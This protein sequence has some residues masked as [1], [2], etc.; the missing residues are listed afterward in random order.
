MGLGRRAAATA[1][2]V[3]MT[4]LGLGAAGC[5][6]GDDG[7]GGGGTA[8]GQDAGTPP[9]ASTAPVPDLVD[10]ADVVA[11]LDGARLDEV[12]VL[13][14]PD[15]RSAYPTSEVRAVFTDELAVFSDT[16]GNLWAVDRDTG[17]PRWHV[18]M[19]SSLPGGDTVCRLA[20][21]SPDA[22]V[23]VANHGGGDLCGE[24]TVYDLRTGDVTLSYS[25]LTREARASGFRLSSNLGMFQLG[26]ST[27]WVDQE[28]R[29][30]RLD[31]TGDSSTV[32]S[33]VILDDKYD[34]WNLA[35][36]QV[37][38][39]T[40]V[41]VARMI[42]PQKGGFDPK[43]FGKP[44]DR[45]DVIGFRFGDD[46]QL[47][48]VFQTS[49]A[50]LVGGAGHVRDS[51]G[52][53]DVLPGLVVDVARQHGTR[54]Y[55]VRAIDPE[56]GELEQPGVLAPYDG[57]ERGGDGVP[58]IAQEYGPDLSLVVGDGTVL[59][60]YEVP[61]RV[62]YTSVV[63]YDM[64]TGKRLW[65]WQLPGG[66][67]SASPPSIKVL[68]VTPD[69]TSAYVFTAMDF[70]NEIRELDLETGRSLRTWQL[71]ERSSYAYEFD[72]APTFVDGDRVLQVNGNGYAR[73]TSLAAL[74]STG[75]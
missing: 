35:R 33:P 74:F 43:T 36:F 45:G 37:I 46:D 72:F 42:P 8:T 60:P 64:A 71:P 9:S 10:G 18:R 13:P 61:A 51:F 12:R 1:A 17:R 75:G 70:D 4:V 28:D 54:Y 52:Q 19:E 65:T 6:S 44:T 50:R 47:E 24:F 62:G 58:G 55:R 29:V 56:S 3:V 21:P 23:V 63:R 38:P 39:G 26:E 48:L 15:Y 11:P 20:L 25:S 59:T 22:S 69:R 27:Y 14:K 66:L 73:D 31:D 34:G 53:D 7:S 57:L 16:R 5:S 32:G 41:F 40:D 67:R 68:G 49:V 30:R 2:A